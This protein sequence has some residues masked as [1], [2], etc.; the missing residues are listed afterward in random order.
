MVG[1]ATVVRLESYNILTRRT[2]QIRIIHDVE[3]VLQGGYILP[4]Y[5]ICIAC[6]W[7]MLPGGVRAIYARSGTYFLWVGSVPHMIDRVQRVLSTDNG[8]TT[9]DDLDDLD[10]D[11]SDENFLFCCRRCSFACAGSAW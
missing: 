10:R 7:S 4:V 2:G 8:S 6:M 9:V 11:L 5:M 3:Y 1:G